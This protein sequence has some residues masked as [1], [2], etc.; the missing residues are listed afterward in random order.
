MINHGFVFSYINPD[1][2]GVA[3]SIAFAELA[4]TTGTGNFKPVIWGHLN[5][6]T[7][8]VLS[9]F[10]IAPPETI[11]NLDGEYAVVLVDTH[12]P[13]QLPDELD[14]T[15]VVQVVD[16]H[17]AGHPEAFPHAQI[18]N[19]K[20]GA[21]ATLLVE[22]FQTAGVE[23]SASTAALLGAAIISNTLNMSAPS[24]DKRDHDALNWVRQRVS[25]LDRSFP[26]QMF[27]ALSAVDEIATADLLTSN[28]KA[29]R[30]GNMDV[31]IVQIESADTDRF[32]AR[33]DLSQEIQALAESSKAAHNFISIVDLVRQRT[34][35]IVGSSDTC[36]L[37]E[38]ALDTRFHPLS[39]TGLSVAEFSRILLRK[40][41]LVPSLEAIL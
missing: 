35:I 6:E 4:R 22:R 9:T 34:T 41:D 7:N 30:T 25:G 10:G 39:E 11:F 23:P 19:E 31:E 16:H 12:H 24:T 2:D 27:A 28:L 15:R 14:T 32:F 17:P 18:Q 3:C 37:L 5:G 1:T 36:S 8:F 38:T 29:F 21:A 33:P 13:Q 40:T 26:Q 20:V